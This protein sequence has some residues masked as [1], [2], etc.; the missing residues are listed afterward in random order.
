MVGSVGD[1]SVARA[2]F[3]GSNPHLKDKSPAILLRTL[4]LEDVQGPLM[5]AARA[6]AA[7]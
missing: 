2:W 3:E 4:P 7:R 5:D 1:P 6:F